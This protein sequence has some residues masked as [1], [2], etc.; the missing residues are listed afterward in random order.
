VY[1]YIIIN[2]YLKERKKEGEREGGRKEE[3]KGERERKEGRK[4]GKE[5]KRKK[6][7]QA[8]SYR[9]LDVWDGNLGGCQ[10][11]SHSLYTDDV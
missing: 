2:K 11:A 1:L 10:T 4:E 8:V 9:Q 6:E 5:R 7:K 3:R